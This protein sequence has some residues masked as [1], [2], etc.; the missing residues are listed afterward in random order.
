MLEFSI[1]NDLIPKVLYIFQAQ[2]G[3][4]L[5]GKLEMPVQIFLCSY[6][7][8]FIHTCTSCIHGYII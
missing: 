8:Y 7:L 5:R 4:R 2:F 1:L 3:H 6:V